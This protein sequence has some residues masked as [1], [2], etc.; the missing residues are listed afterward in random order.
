MSELNQADIDDIANDQGLAPESA[1]PVETTIL[2]ARK[3]LLLQVRIQA[4]DELEVHQFMN[5]RPS[6]A[7]RNF[8]EADE[9]Q[10]A[11]HSQE[12]SDG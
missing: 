7:D 8:V 9:L 4:A 6:L 1:Y 10:A 11:L 5:Y 2:L 3:I 12:P